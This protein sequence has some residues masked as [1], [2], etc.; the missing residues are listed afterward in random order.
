[1]IWTAWAGLLSAWHGI[2]AQHGIGSGMGMGW[3]TCA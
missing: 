2:N 3:L 1:M